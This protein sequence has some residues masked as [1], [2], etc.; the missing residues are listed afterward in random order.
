MGLKNGVMATLAL[1][2]PFHHDYALYNDGF[3]W[4]YDSL[5][6]VGFLDRLGSLVSIGFL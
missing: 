3:L 4:D 2:R 5:I 6:L 1:P